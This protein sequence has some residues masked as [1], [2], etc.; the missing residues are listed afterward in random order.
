[1]GAIGL[2]GLQEKEVIL[3]ISQEVA[4]LLKQQGVQ[5]MMTRDSDYFVSLQGRTDMANRAGVDLFVSIHANSMGQGRPDVSGLEVYYFGNQA[6]ASTIQ[7]SILRTVNIKDR[8]VRQAR[9][10]VLRKSAMPATLVEVG[11]VTGS[12]DAANLKNPTYRRQMA[13]AIAR[14]TLE[15]IQQ[16][17]R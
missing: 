5:V 4:Q 3:S 9:F 15:Y 6:L 12:Q 2:S 14:G 8:G 11:F 17:K 16:N 13:L 10:Y 1:M 7:K